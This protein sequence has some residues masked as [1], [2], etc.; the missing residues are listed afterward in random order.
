MINRTSLFVVFLLNAA[1]A[2]A[3][4]ACEPDATPRAKEAKT[5]LD[6]FYTHYTIRGYWGFF[7]A[8]AKG[9]NVDVQINVPE[10]QAQDLMKFVADDRLKFIARNS[11]PPRGEEVWSM[12]DPEG[13]IIIHA[14]LNGNPF[15]EASCKNNM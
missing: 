10:R 4:V 3:M 5:W 2:V 15:A 13:D 8:D 7:G 9:K 12:L 14:R 1:V 11:C 6:K